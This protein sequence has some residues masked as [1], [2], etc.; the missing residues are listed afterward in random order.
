MRSQLF[1]HNR[2][3]QNAKISLSI[4]LFIYGLL[5][6]FTRNCMLSWSLHCLVMS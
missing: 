1:S 2:T 5:S 4:H 6:F 3:R